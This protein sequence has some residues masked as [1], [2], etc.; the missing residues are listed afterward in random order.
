MKNT[1]QEKLLFSGAS[2]AGSFQTSVRGG[3]YFLQHRENQ[4]RGQ[5]GAN[6]LNC[7]RECKTKPSRPPQALSWQLFPY[8]FH[9]LYS[10]TL[11][12]IC[13]DTDTPILVV[14][15]F[16][17]ADRWISCTWW[18][19]S[20]LSQVP[21][22]TELWERSAF[23]VAS[24]GLRCVSWRS[25]RYVFAYLPSG[26]EPE[27]RIHRHHALFWAGGKEQWWCH[28]TAHHPSPWNW[29]LLLL[30]TFCYLN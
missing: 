22:V 23:S 16:Q 8:L 24:S 18:V 27:G 17:E 29:W 13:V 11:L 21:H 12:L 30:L 19:C 6:V 4:R 20:C 1:P 9:F 7:C 28:M 3:N 15:G 10:L 26:S 14:Y 2:L 25:A 5:K